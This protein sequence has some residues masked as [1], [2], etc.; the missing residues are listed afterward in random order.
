MTIFK[1][2]DTIIETDVED[3]TEEEID[4]Y[5]EVVFN[6]N[7]GR[8]DDI[9]KITVSKTSEEDKVDVAFDKKSNVKFERLNRI[10]GYL[11]EVSNWNDGSTTCMAA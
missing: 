4:K 10:T 11:S 8:M 9:L 5:Y 3:I 1:K 2:N 7:K 6:Y